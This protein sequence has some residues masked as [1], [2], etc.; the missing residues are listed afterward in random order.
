MKEIQLQE[1][2]TTVQLPARQNDVPMETGSFLSL[3]VM[4]EKFKA[5]QKSCKANRTIHDGTP[6]GYRDVHAFG[7][8][9]ENPHLFAHSGKSLHIF[10]PVTLHPLLHLPLNVLVIN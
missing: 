4:L 6:K 7:L 5:V 10:A 2:G 1:C 8:A 3:H 9:A